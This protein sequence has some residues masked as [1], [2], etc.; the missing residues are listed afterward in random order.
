M[1]S[2]LMRA[3]AVL[4]AMLLAAEA[5]VG[6]GPLRSSTGSKP[7]PGLGVADQVYAL[8]F[9]GVDVVSRAQLQGGVDEGMAHTAS[10]PRLEHGLEDM[11]PLAQAITQGFRCIDATVEHVEQP[12]LSFNGSAPAFQPF[13]G[14]ESAEDAALVGEGSV[15][16]LGWRVAVEHYLAGAGHLHQHQAKGAVH[17]L[18]TQLQDA[19]GAQSGA[20]HS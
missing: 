15:D 6:G 10:G 20:G 13:L 7:V 1:T 4:K 17:L 11:E 19:S 9:R 3:L 5:A 16:A 12:S 14:H 18:G 8:D 2:P